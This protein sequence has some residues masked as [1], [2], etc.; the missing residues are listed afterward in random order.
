MNARIAPPPI[1]P[2]PKTLNGPHRDRRQPELVV[3]GV[4]HVLARELR[5]RVR[6][7]RLADRAGRRGVRLVDAEGV[8]A[9]DLARR[10]VDEPLE[11]VLASRARPRARCTCRSC[12]RASSAPGSRA[13]CRRPRSPRSGRCASR[14]A[15]ARARA[16]ASSTSP[17]TKVRF[18]WSASSRAGERVAVQVVERDD[19]V[20]VDQPPRE[21]RRD[22]AGAAREEDPLAAQ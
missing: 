1:W 19:L 22:E 6:P 4:R 2:G 10:E 18:G 12:S 3:V 13:R 15:R 14:P 11:R 5:D 20:V 7:A 17:C 8:R 16:R 21:R 9:E